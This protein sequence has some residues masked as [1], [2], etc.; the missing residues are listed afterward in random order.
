MFDEIVNLG[1]LVR[2]AQNGDFDNL[3]E[4]DK[5]FAEIRKRVNKYKRKTR[6]AFI[7]NSTCTHEECCKPY[8]HLQRR[9]IDYVYVF[10]KDCLKCG[11]HFFVQDNGDKYNE[12]HMP[13]G[14]EGSEKR[15]YNNSF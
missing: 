9:M 4:I 10:Q 6:A 8:W 3:R 15:Y 5:E 14:Y 11:K 2:E 12:K 1:S 13:E 7:E